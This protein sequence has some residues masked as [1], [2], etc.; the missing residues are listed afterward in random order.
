MV[1]KMN[2]S[3]QII[4]NWFEKKGWAPFPF[5]QSCWQAF[6]DGKSGLLNAPTGSGKTYALLLPVLCEALSTARSNKS[7]HISGIRAIWI[8]PIRALA[9]EIQLATEAAIQGLGINW[10]V[11]VRSGDT[12]AAER[13]QMQKNPPEI[14]IT[15]PES[16]HL[17]LATKGYPQFFKHLEAVIIDEW[18]ELLGTKRGVQIELARSRLQQLRP[19][20]KVWGISATIGNLEEAKFV[21]LGPHFKGEAVLIKSEQAKTIEVKAIIPEEIAQLPWSGHLGIKLLP[22]LIPI[23][24][25][26]KSTIIFTNTRAQCEIWYQQLLDYSPDLAGLMAMHHGSLSRE[27]RDWVEESLHNGQLKVVVS[28]SSLDLGV[29]FRPVETVVQIGSPKGVGRFMQRAGR[30]GHQPGAA[31]TIYFLPTHAL[32]LLEAAA[33]RK[34]IAKNAIEQRPPLLRSFD[35]LIQY[36]VTLAVSDGFQPDEVYKEIKNTFSFETV[37][38]VEWNWLLSFI[39]TGGSL[40]RYDDFQKVE[41]TEGLLKVTSRKIAM[42]HRLSIGAIVGDVHMQVKFV[43]GK[44][45][46]NVEEW[47]IGQLKPGDIFQFAGRTLELVRVKDMVAQVRKSGSKTKKIPSWLGGRLPLSSQLSVVLR[48]TIEAWRLAEDPDKELIALQPMATLQ[49]KLSHI[50]TRHELLIEYIKSREGY[51]LLVY[52]FEGRYVHEGISA[53]LAWR[54]SRIRPITF[55]IAMN[56]YGFELLSDAEIPIKQALEQGCFSTHDLFADIQKSL[57][58]V[59]MARRQFRDIAAIAGLVFKGFPGK[60]KKDRHL[61]ASSSLLFDVFRD[62]EPDNLLFQQAYDEVRHFQLEEGRLRLAL[63]RINKQQIIL[64]QPSRFTP[65]SFPIV[66]DRLRE[67]LSS[68]KLEDRIRKMTLESLS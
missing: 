8:T 9:R 10:R 44:F 13:R 52:P 62:Y 63:R 1:E 37:S 49:Q 28:T 48:D 43:S 32:E 53:L 16:L 50:P 11:G 47:F 33:L 6:L 31:S 17:L 25:G 65:F 61:Q 45:L 38:E 20:L 14:L 12:S 39:C 40:H 68:E 23:I 46:G 24:E 66:T 41:L 26:S 67:T 55:T 60:K 30:S 29:D 19:Q 51:H 35:V 4:E 7:I 15:T 57:N 3:I 18:H 56:D 59:Q 54:L 58:E 42:R 64:T 27:I 21:L 5:Q 2:N 22:S 36:L 34:A